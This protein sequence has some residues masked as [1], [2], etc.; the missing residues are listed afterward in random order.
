[1]K[2]MAEGTVH[3]GM[4]VTTPRRK[5]TYPARE[6]MCFPSQ[7]SYEARAQKPGPHLSTFRDRSAG[8]QRAP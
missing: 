7:I 2:N 8:E 3:I 6:G 5:G 4:Q 1:M